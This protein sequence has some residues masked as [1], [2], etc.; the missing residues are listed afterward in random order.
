MNIN[1]TTVQCENI[2]K[3]YIQ[4]DLTVDVL[5]NVNIQIPKKS[6]I[7]IIGQSG[8]GKSTLLNILGTLDKP[9][10]GEIYINDVNINNLSDKE[11]SKIRNQHIGFV[12]QSHHLFPEFTAIENVMLPSLIRNNN[13][14]KCFHDAMNL[15]SK[16]GLSD[17]CNH[18]PSELSGGEKQRISIARSLINNPS[19]I[20]MD[21]PTGNLDNKSTNMIID[22]IH[23]ISSD[24]NSTFLIATHDND[25]AKDMDSVFMLEDKEIHKL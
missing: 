10:T 14:N 17:R 21:E 7:S 8:V 3:S 20:L 25:V 13:K 5:K 11:L 22:L 19:F 12:Y 24:F 16:V 4:G 9:S 6:K 2:S 1:D 23:K 15:I 18:R